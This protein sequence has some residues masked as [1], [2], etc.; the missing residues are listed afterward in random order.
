MGQ[1]YE[2]DNH[3][4]DRDNVR[5]PEGSE[6]TKSCYKACERPVRPQRGTLEE[7]EKG[8][9]PR[10]DDQNTALGVRLTDGFVLHVCAVRRTAS[11]G[12]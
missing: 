6:W 9:V 4:G 8:D 1:T 5:V 7:Q 3:T 11:C 12:N 10:S 2:F